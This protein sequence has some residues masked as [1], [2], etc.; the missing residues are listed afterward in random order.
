[1]RRVFLSLLI[2]TICGLAFKY[3]PFCFAHAARGASTLVYDR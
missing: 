1:M 2:T 3:F